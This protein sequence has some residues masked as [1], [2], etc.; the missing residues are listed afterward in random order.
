MIK[1]FVLLGLVVGCGI[2]SSV[3]AAQLSV[4]QNLIP[5]GWISA[6]ETQ[7]VFDWDDVPLAN[8]YRI[9]MARANSQY[10]SPLENF[11]GDGCAAGAECVFNQGDI[12]QSEFLPPY[13]LK[14]GL[15]LWRVRA[16]HTTNTN[17][18]PSDWNYGDTAIRLSTPTNA[19]TNIT[20][21][22]P[23]FNWDV[24]SFADNYRIQVSQSNNFLTTDSLEQDC[25]NCVINQ[26]PTQNNYQVTQPLSS[27]TYYW[28]IRAGANTSTLIPHSEWTQTYSFNISSSSS[29]TSNTSNSPTVLI[30]QTSIGAPYSSDNAR[31]AAAGEVRHNIGIANT[32]WRINSGIYTRVDQGWTNTG[33]N[34]AWAAYNI[35]LQIGDNVLEVR[36]CD[37]SGICGSASTTITRAADQTSNPTLNIDSVSP[38][39]LVEG[40]AKE[41]DSNSWFDL[42]IKGLGF[43]T[44]AT[45]FI[46]GILLD[47]IRVNNGAEI[48]ARIKAVYGSS[49]NPPV[50]EGDRPVTVKNTDNTRIDKIGI[51]TVENL[52]NQPPSFQYGRAYPESVVTGAAIRF[53]TAWIDPEKNPIVDVFVRYRRLGGGIAP[54]G[55]WK[56]IILPYMQGTTSPVVFA[57]TLIINEIIGVYEYQFRAADS[58]SVEP[59]AQR[60]HTT[61]WQAGGSFDVI[62]QPANNQ[63]PTLQ[64]IGQSASAVMPN[65]DFSLKLKASDPDF[66]LKEIQI[67]WNGKGNVTTHTVANG[68]SLLVSHTYPT[69]GQIY[70]TATAYDLSG[71]KSKM[72]RGSVWVGKLPT[73]NAQRSY[74]SSKISLTANCQSSCQSKKVSQVGDPI[75]TSTGAQVIDYTL[76]SVK[77]L[78]TLAFTLS[79]NSL[80]LNESIAGKGWDVGG[81]QIKLET[82][83]DGNLNLYWSANTY[84]LFVLQEDG[85]YLSFEPATRF[86]VITKKAD[87]SF[88]LTRRNKTFYEFDNAGRLVSL[89]NTKGQVVSISYDNNGRLSQIIEPISGVFLKYAYNA[90]GLLESVTDSIDRVV[91]LTYDAQKHLTSITD[92]ANQTTT[93]TYDTEGRILTAVSVDK[94]QLFANQYDSQGRVISQDDGLTST[95]LL[96]LAYSENTDSTFS[97]TVTNRDNTQQVYTYNAQNQLLSIRNALNQTTRSTYGDNSLLVRAE[98][99]NGKGIDLEYDQNANLIK[100][101]DAKGAIETIE[102][103]AHNNPIIIR[104]ARNGIWR[105]TYDAQDNPLTITDVQNQTTTL[106][107]NAE[108]LLE[109]IKTPTG[110]QI[111]YTYQN[112]LPITKTDAEGNVEKRVFDLAGRLV[113][114]I[115]PENHS[116]KMSYDAVNRITSLKDALNQVVK[117]TYNAKDKVI[118]IED[119]MG[120]VTSNDYDANGHLIATINPLKQT[121]RFE[122]DAEGRLIKAIDAKGNVVVLQRDTLGRVISTTDALGNTRRVEYDAV[123]NVQQRMDALGN[124][125]VKYLFDEVYNP[126][127]IADALGN[128]S[129]FSF[130]KSGTLTQLTDAL[131]R[132]TQFEH[133]I[134]GR[135]QTSIDALKGKSEQAFDLEG[136]LAKLQD[137]KNNQT[138]FQHNKNG[139]VIAQ[140]VA[141]D[142]TVRYGYNA[143]NLLK[144]I[145]NARSQKRTIEYDAVGQP[146]K[147]TDPDGTISI[148]YDANGNVLTITDNNGTISREY[149]ALNRVIK[150]TNQRGETI[151]YVYD[152]LGQRSAIIYPDGK[153]VQYAY[154]SVGH[155]I[156]VTDWANRI[157]QYQYDANGR[158]IKEER[159][160]GSIGT[161][162]YNVAGQLTQLKDVTASGELINQADFTYDAAGNITEE[163]RAFETEIFPLP[164]E[165]TYGAGNR[166]ATYNG[167]SITHDADGNM[168]NCPVLGKMATCEFNSRNLLTRINDTQYLY[169]A[170]NHRVAIQQGTQ[171]TRFTINPETALSQVL[172]KNLSINSKNSNT[173]YVYGLGLIG[174]ETNGQYRTY[175]YDLRGS[176]VALTDSTGKITERYAYS[177]YGELLTNQ[178]PST[179]FLYNGR[180]GV[181]TDTNGLYYMRARFYSPDLKRFLNQDP[182]ML[183]AVEEGQTLNRYAY[184]NGEPVSLV[185]PLGLF[186][187]P[188][189]S[190]CTINP[191]LCLYLANNKIVAKKDNNAVKSA[192]KTRNTTNV[193]TGVKFISTFHQA[194]QYVADANN[195][196]TKMNGRVATSLDVLVSTEKVYQ[197]AQ[198]EGAGKAVEVGVVELAGLAGGEAAFEGCAGATGAVTAELGTLGGVIT[199]CAGAACAYFGEDAVK[200]KTESVIQQIEQ[201]KEKQVDTFIHPNGARNEREWIQEFIN[202][203]TYG[204]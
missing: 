6:T 98:D 180:D 177:M 75:E 128:V 91:R 41:S 160:N 54:D 164:A 102:Y 22:I 55:E 194:I 62:G 142:S 139:Q 103:N 45:V 18:F 2:L 123:G 43:N 162:T 186:L 196:E 131:G 34:G 84:N 79:Y 35:P 120:N 76:L 59:N 104:D 117:L 136:N 119:A 58:V 112:G 5:R 110:N 193:E 10:P 192:S 168:L 36:A 197:A 129:K 72:L 39:R 93:F 63:P 148:K 65:R 176:T 24:V 109:S 29:T 179:S 52:S 67:D 53:E 92:A 118:S 183:G 156:K 111:K 82:L 184:V 190:M 1:R 17:L 167:Q 141:N 137:P 187:V 161:R 124:V 170:E 135:L 57:K 21:A 81:A 16:G 40:Q 27:G 173:Y 87:G 25:S 88:V 149:D 99:A 100:T 153:K 174:E 50:P 96:K 200:N 166:L 127:Q 199:F 165:M 85:S 147:I 46:P 146:I 157:T 152:E 133:D 33:G 12:F 68:E 204:C 106:A 14:P 155:L 159:P 143:R 48:I 56:E 125:S 172:V 77:G 64:L 42:T 44:G 30:S 150:H 26:I 47:N 13:A 66:N 140:T 83:A 23:T 38:T 108:G 90:N 188:A 15:Y 73:A 151:Q 163:K 116:L 181:M 86:D 32:E 105:I 71:A 107:Y 20:N 144:D 49:T 185:D 80:L 70:W 115:D 97:T 158:L 101:T 28:R 130:D 95:P 126:V 171:Q 134:I 201:A 132:V 203:T 114:I 61:D 122:Y 189:L 9:Q 78:Q 74:Q 69:N 4:P 51:L 31:A 11:V 8:T 89:R 175:H 195:M 121:T 169:D 182:L 94:A 202:C 138:L 191:I 178:T 154:D 3:E 145:T 198:Q 19:N 37:T 60:L 7:P 113:E